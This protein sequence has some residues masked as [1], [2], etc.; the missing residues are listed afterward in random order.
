[1][2]RYRGGLVGVVGLERLRQVFN[3]TDTET[4]WLIVGA[5]EEPE[6]LPDISLIYSED[7]TQLPPELAGVEWPRKNYISSAQT[8]REQKFQVHD[9]HSLNVQHPRRSYF[10]APR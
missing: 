5:P 3:N 6:F 9:R 1:M 2:K 4:L 8:G 7:P 10:V